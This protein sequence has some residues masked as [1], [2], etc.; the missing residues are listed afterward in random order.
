MEGYELGKLPGRLATLDSWAAHLSD[1]ELEYLIKKLGVGR[2]KAVLVGLDSKRFE[3][4]REA[5]TK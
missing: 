2:V 5:R 3:H 1:S 4:W